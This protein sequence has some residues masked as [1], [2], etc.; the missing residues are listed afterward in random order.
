MKGY[1]TGSW[2]RG[3]WA[4][5]SGESTQF[6]LRPDAY[7]LI[8]TA[9]TTHPPEQKETTHMITMMRQESQSGSW[10]DFA[11]MPTKHCLAD[12]LTKMS[13]DPTHLIQTVESGWVQSMDLYPLF[14]NTVRRSYFIGDDSDS[15]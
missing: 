13:C 1:G 3:L 7:N 8:T 4:D 12:C 15:E 2:I 14:R 9:R 5:I 10:D 6:H 11:H